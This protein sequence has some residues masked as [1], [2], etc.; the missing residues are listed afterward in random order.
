MLANLLLAELRGQLQLGVPLHLLHLS[1]EDRAGDLAG[2]LSN[3]GIRIDTATIY[4][5]RAAKALQPQTV[6]AFRSDK[7]AA[8]LHYS[9]RSAA[10]F[11]QLVQA[12]GI[13]DEVVAARHFCL[14]Q[15]IATPLQLFG[16]NPVV[17]VAPHEDALLE[18]LEV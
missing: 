9:E 2:V 4:R 14:S 13:T 10:I 12:A 7:I 8:A 3:T 15:A 5:A 11:V 6:D 18:L 16:L 17:A 1:G